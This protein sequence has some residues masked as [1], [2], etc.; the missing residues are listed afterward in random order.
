MH[1]ENV[2]TPKKFAIQIYNLCKNVQPL[3]LKMLFLDCMIC[4]PSKTNIVI[5]THALEVYF[6]LPARVLFDEFKLF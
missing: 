2:V 3:Y 5:S 4:C 6:F 1:Q